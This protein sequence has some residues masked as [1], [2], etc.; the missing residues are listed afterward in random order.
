MGWIIDTKIPDPLLISTFSWTRV[1]KL[2]SK[3]F[4]TGHIS[5]PMM[6]VCR[7]I[8]LKVMTTTTTQNDDYQ[9]NT[10]QSIRMKETI[11]LVKEA[12]LR[13]IQNRMVAQELASWLDVARQSID[14]GG[15]TSSRT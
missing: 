14:V 1:G 5:L 4:Q 7:N 3:V 6:E 2:F 12:D 10:I 15:S 9:L 11:D 13:R 8:F